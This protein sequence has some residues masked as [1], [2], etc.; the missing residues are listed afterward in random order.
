MHTCPVCWF[1]NLPYPANDYHICPCCGTEFGNDDAEFSWDELRE[2]WV[3][4]GANWFF[5]APPDGWNPQA[6]LLAAG[7][8]VKMTVSSERRMAYGE[9]RFA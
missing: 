3:A 9:L 1:S 4:Q 5:G 2:R 8:G 6:Q 7:Y